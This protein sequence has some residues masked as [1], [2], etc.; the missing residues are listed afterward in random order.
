[1]ATASRD[2]DDE[3]LLELKQSVPH[4][5]SCAARQATTPRKKVAEMCSGLNLGC[6]HALANE[7]DEPVFVGETRASTSCREEGKRDSV[8]GLSG[9]DPISRSGRLDIV[10]RSQVT[11]V[12]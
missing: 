5:A 10:V 11:Q 9:E 7:G 8:S 3:G 1:M 2:D 12:A 6:V 4:S